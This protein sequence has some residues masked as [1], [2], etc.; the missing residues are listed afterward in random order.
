MAVPR[1]NM[2]RSRNRRARWEART[3]TLIAVTGDGATYRGQQYQ[4]LVPACR[5]GLLRPE[6]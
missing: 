2:S 6:G 1:H 3:P 5:R 4:H